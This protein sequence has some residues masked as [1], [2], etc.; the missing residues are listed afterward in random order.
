MDQRTDLTVRIKLQD[1]NGDALKIE[2]ASFLFAAGPINKTSAEGGG[3]VIADEE[4]G[5]I[6]VV[7]THDDVQDAPAHYRYELLM[8]DVNGARY[9]PLKG[10]LIVT[11]SITARR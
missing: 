8:T 10:L 5:V 1:E 6:E 2:G 9:I 3:I 7:I 11:P 4:R